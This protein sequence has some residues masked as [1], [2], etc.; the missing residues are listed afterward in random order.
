VVV[1]EGES[2]LATPAEGGDEPVELAGL[3]PG[4]A[5]AV[6]ADRYQAGLELLRRRGEQIFILDDGFQHRRLARDLDLVCIDAGESDDHLRL[7]PAGRLREPLANL[8]RAGALIWTRW[9]E[10]RPAES[11]SARVLPWLTDRRPVFRSVSAIS[12]F[13]SVPS[14]SHGLPAEAL[15]GESVGLLSGIAGPGRFREDLE[16]CGVRIVWSRAE[17]DHHTWRP[18]EVASLLEEARRAGARAVVTTGK[19]AVKMTAMGETPVPLYRALLESRVVEREA[20]EAL[21]DAL[22][23][24]SH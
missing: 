22:P 3:V 6:G 15:R 9:R 21:L 23:R 5:V 12:G 2:V 8:N 19:D 20:F 17:R 1:S 18:D 13:Q 24:T 11:L 4:L 7:L 10:G 14:P 16:R